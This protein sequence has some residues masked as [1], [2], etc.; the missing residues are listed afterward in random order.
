VDLPKSSAYR[1]LCTLEHRGYAE[2]DEETGNY[3]VGLALLFVVD[4]HV[5]ILVR[6]AR[7]YLEEL[8]EKFAE[9]LNLGILDGTRVAY[10]DITESPHA[11]R[12]A[13]R[14]GDRDPIHSTAL[15]KA[16][17]SQLP[18][19]EVRRILEVEGMQQQTDSTIT[20]QEAYFE[21][22]ALTRKR[23]FALDNGE[24]DAG[25]RCIAVPG[26]GGRVPFAISLS[27]PSARFARGRVPEIASG[28]TDAVQRLEADLS[29]LQ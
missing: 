21:E 17:A 20:D 5:Q 28:L 29:K 10:L 26:R 25:G 12:M 11:L 19:P 4:E 6:S 8:R 22:M 3:R 2:R 15:G 7:P 13:S 1:H 9:T 24:S 27:A 18:E 23:G 14:L 16:I